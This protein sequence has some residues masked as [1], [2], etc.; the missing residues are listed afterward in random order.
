MAMASEKHTGKADD[1]WYLPVEHVRVPKTHFHDLTWGQ[2][3]KHRILR[4]LAPTTS[5]SYTEKYAY[6]T[7]TFVDQVREYSSVRKQIKQLYLVYRG[8]R[9]A[10]LK[11]ICDS[12]N[13]AEPPP[14]WDDEVENVQNLLQMSGKGIP[15]NLSLPTALT[16]N[17]RA[18]QV[19]QAVPSDEQLAES[20][21]QL[22]Q[23]E[24]DLLDD[25]CSSIKRTRLLRSHLQ[26]VEEDL[27]NYAHLVNT[28][29]TA[30]LTY[31]RGFRDWS[32]VM[33]DLTGTLSNALVAISTLGA[34]LIYS[35]VFGASRGN[36]ALMCYCF[37]FFSVGFLLP[38]ITQIILTWGASMKREMR[39]ASQRFWTIIVGVLMSI[40]SLAV[41]AS[42]TILNLTVFLLKSDSGD[43][44]IP[45][46]N[47]TSMAP[48]IIAFS[49]TGA[50][51]L[52]V[53]MGALLSAIAAKAITT[54]KGIRGVLSAMY[55]VGGQGQD[56]LKLWLPV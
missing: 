50:V 38:V 21:N 46:E 2:A 13:L 35:T 49:V 3:I 28:Q 42:L 37:P 10:Q 36:V 44:P 31:F 16:H 27:A 7:N 54:V 11:E 14:Q 34:G 45:G 53:M 33:L 51:F 24:L 12:L 17:T 40:S 8:H 52:L 48:G 29:A 18:Y 30:E 15:S 4:F 41:M 47:P 26:E 5:N 39:F 6:F 23:R 22:T 25:Y 9:L 43:D 55:G 32:R 56:A 19:L 1:A 20:K